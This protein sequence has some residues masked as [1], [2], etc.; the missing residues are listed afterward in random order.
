MRI[1]MQLGVWTN[2]DC[3]KRGVSDA[4]IQSKKQWIGTT[5]TIGT[6][7]LR[8][9]STKEEREYIVEYLEELFGQN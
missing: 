9:Y 4:L 2:I 8:A 7:H 5:A 6:Q 1:T 3:E